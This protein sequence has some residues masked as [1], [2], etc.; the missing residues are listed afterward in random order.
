MFPDGFAL[1]AAEEVLGPD[2]L[3]SVESLVGQSLLTVRES[4]TGLRYRMLET[5][6]EFGGLRLRDEP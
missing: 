1:D 2:A 3:G 4:A 6:R 5:V